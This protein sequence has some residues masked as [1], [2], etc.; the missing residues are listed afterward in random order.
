MVKTVRFTPWFDG[1]VKPAR[2]GVYQLMS[3]T[4]STVGYQYWDGHRWSVW[5]LTP[6]EAEKHKGLS[7]DPM[8]HDDDWRGLSENI[9]ERD[10]KFVVHSL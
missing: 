4:R 9:E 5:R 3:G 1:R 7:A 10:L 6:K 8:Y 2:A